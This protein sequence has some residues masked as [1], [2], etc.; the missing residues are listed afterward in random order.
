M[1]IKIA[2]KLI[3]D[4]HPVFFIAELS[5]NHNQDFDLTLKTIRAMKEAGAD[6]V[7]VQTFNA[8]TLTIN[9]DKED[10]RIKGGTLWDGA[11]L[12][13]LYQGAY[14]P[15]EWHEPLKKFVNDLGMVF[16]STPTDR[17]SADFLEKLE[18][19]VYK[20]ASFEITDIP[21]IEH[22]ARKGKP[23]II[24]TGVAG[25]EEINDAL[26]ACR[27]VNNEEVILLKCTSAYPTPWNDVHLNAIPL[28]RERYHKVV[29]LS[30]HTMGDIVALGA[31]T[32]GARV[33]EKHFILER[34]LGGPDA[35]FSMEPEEFK[36]M[37]H[38]VRD[39]EKAL[40]NRSVV[41]PESAKMNKQFERSLYVVEDIQAGEIFTEKN[42]RS[43]RP[44][45]GMKPKFYRVVLGKRS[46]QDIERGTPLSPNLISD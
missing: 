34:S 8:D 38:R 15:W 44:G 7:K 10:F 32:L 4:K 29:G 37:V 26:E 5:A 46:T 1:T 2:D 36:T 24:S 42:V 14:M 11:T 3:D 45:F 28:I 41:I 39:L 6:A 30:D 25:D 43:I 16:F 20:I 9:S 35:S 21:L 40:G 23:V 19:P 17:V 13:D 18:M 22:V 12:Y 33:V 31:V 27:R